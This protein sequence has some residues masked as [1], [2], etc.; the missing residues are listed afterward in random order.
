MLGGP[1]ARNLWQSNRLNGG[2][3]VT[4]DDNFV[5]YDKDSVFANDEKAPATH[6]LQTQASGELSATDFSEIMEKVE[7]G[8]G[9]RI[10][11]M[12]NLLQSVSGYEN[13]VPEQSLEDT[14]MLSSSSVEGE[15]SVD[16]HDG[17]PDA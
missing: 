12:I 14:V 7:V 9:T 3:V 16:D 4:N 6:S 11:D 10:D 13:D 1:S 15:S 8:D 17:A 5:A 2:N